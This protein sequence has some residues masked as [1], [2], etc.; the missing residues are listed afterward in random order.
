MSTAL[1]LGVIASC[2]R[3]GS[4]TADDAG[5]VAALIAEVRRS[6][7]LDGKQIPPEIFRD[8][9]DGDLAD[10]GSIW[11]TVDLKAAIGSNLY[12]DD[13]RKNGDWIGQKKAGLDEATA[14]THIGTTENGLLVVLAAFSGGGSGSFIFLHILDAA[15]ARAFDFNGNIYERINL[16][17]L[18][19]IPLG[20]R[21]GGE[22]G[23]EKNTIT[24]TTTRKGPADDSGLRET[25]AIEATRP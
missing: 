12:F 13:I 20:D 8:F 3:P 1:A 7:T 14:Y 19:S 25:K 11:V 6:F 9:G 23:I 18:R 22:I 24:I 17:N 15:A 2:L 5:S 21:W 16:T 4:A 10:S